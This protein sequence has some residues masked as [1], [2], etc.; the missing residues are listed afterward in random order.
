MTKPAVRTVGISKSYQ[1]GSRWGSYGR[2]SEV[3]VSLFTA[4][5]EK[6][7][8]AEYF[9][10][11][12]DIEFEVNP[13]ET[14]GVIGSN[15][16][17]KSTLL[18]IL[19]RITPPTEGRCYIR[20]K[21]TSLLEVGTGFHPELTGRENIFLNGTIMGMSRTSIKR[22]FDEI[23]DF[24]Q[25]EKS[26]D[27]AVKHYSSGMYLRLAFAIAAHLEQDIVLMDEVLAVGDATFQQR[28]MGKIAGLASDGTTVLFVSH[29]M[30]AVA[31]L[32][33]RVLVLETGRAMLIDNPQTAISTYLHSCRNFGRS[34]E[35]RYTPKDVDVFI[36]NV[37]L[38]TEDGSVSD[39]FVQKNFWVEVEVQCNR[40]VNDVEV[41]I[42]VQ[43]SLGANVL[44]TGLSDNSGSMY[45]FTPGTHT[46]RIDFPGDFFAP[47]SYFLTVWSMRPYIEW[48]DRQEQCVQFNIVETGSYLWRYPGKHFSAVLL[49]LPWKRQ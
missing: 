47:D 44:M 23:V 43:N 48:L 29:Q 12:K 1:R 7:S 15:G 38:S 10:A 39:I 11:L 30:G 6:Q 28:C 36:T 5:K 19:S 31:E 33:N 24:A 40:E 20:G 46:F 26:L 13:G 4:K 45:S 49:K 41:C 22:R 2:F 18:K 3:L 17:G 32:C 42:F 21:L 25:V 34:S 27:T 8:K 37:T 35:N 14:F 16:S 9:W